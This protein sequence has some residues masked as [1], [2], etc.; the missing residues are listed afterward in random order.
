MTDMDDWIS[1]LGPTKGK[2]ETEP[3]L[4]SERDKCHLC[5]PHRM[6]CMNGFLCFGEFEFLLDIFLLI[7]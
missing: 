1:L 5:M 2:D 6:L 3:P 4:G 7:F